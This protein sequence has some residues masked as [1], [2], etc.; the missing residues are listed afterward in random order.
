MH[1]VPNLAGRAFNQF[2]DVRDIRDS[3]INKCCNQLFDN[4]KQRSWDQFTIG[5]K[6]RGWQWVDGCDEYRGTEVTM[7]HS[8]M[9][10]LKWSNRRTAA[11]WANASTHC[12]TLTYNGVTGWRLPTTTELVGAYTNGISAAVPRTNWLATAG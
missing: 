9:G 8:A 1:D 5:N 11:T 4:G 12:S 10:E 6:D 7:K 2:N 3:D